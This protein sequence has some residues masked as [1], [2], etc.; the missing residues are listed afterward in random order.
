M[1]ALD[2]KGIDYRRIDLVPAVHKAVQKV[3][4]GGGTVPGIVFEDGEKVLGSRAIIRA[5]EIR[6]PDPSLFPADPDEY[7]RVEEA[8]EWGDQA[9]QPLVRRVLWL[10]LS[11]D[12]AA[13]LSYLDGAKLVPPTPRA[14]AR[15]SG[16]AVAWLERRFNDS[17]QATV[18]AD[19]ANLP[20]HLDRVD[21][22][23]EQ[24]VLGGDGLNAA[25]LQI[26][27][28]LRLLMTVEDVRPQI[29]AR[30]AGA[31]ARRVF[32]ADPGHVPNGAL[33]PG[34]LEAPV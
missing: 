18:R 24:G 9:L 19:L 12:T 23:I 1:R 10:A 5:A 21:R 8:E 25:D 29:D 33:P 7:R 14:V 31:F 28:G 20:A 32:P 3:L 27:S 17:T 6:R 22:W 2:L 30:P 15:V 16:G 34:W 13:Q 26:A 11:R 4:F